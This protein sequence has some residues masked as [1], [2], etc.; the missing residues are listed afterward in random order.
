MRVWTYLEKTFE[1][2]GAERWQVTWQEL[3]EQARTRMDG[4]RP[5][6]EA[7]DFNYDVD[8]IH[9]F[10]NF[11]TKDAA[12]AYAKQVTDAGETFFGAA[13]VQKQIV[14]WYVEEDHVA[15]WADIGDAACVP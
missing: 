1:Q 13:S 12:M 10:A 15:E 3:T 2:L 6:S 11:S 7:A 5:D 8:L 14:D 9:R 4:A